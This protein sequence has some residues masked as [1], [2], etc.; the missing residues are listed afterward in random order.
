MKRFV[1]LASIGLLLGGVAWAS[2]RVA[3]GLLPRVR[4]VA[5]RSANGEDVNATILGCHVASAQRTAGNGAIL[6]VGRLHRP[7]QVI[8]TVPSRGVIVR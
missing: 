4:I 6:R 1:L 5:L 7:A 8:T 2:P 3:N